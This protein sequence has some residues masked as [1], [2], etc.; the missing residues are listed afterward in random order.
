MP[1]PS[2]SQL[3]R[4]NREFRLLWMGQ[5]VS[6]LGDW[7]NF[8]TIQAL[9][10]RLTGEATSL[11]GVWVAQ[12]LPLLVVGPVAGVVVDRLPRKAVMIAADLAR[13]G[14]AL[15]FLLIH[16]STWWLAYP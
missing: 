1:S 12:S 4:Q 15:G 10:L 11:A 2:Y 7:F 6:L 8:V 3:L 5:A 13:A 16:R 9:L 14:V